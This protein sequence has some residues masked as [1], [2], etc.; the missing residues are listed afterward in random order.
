M[1]IPDPP[2]RPGLWEAWTP[3]QLTAF[4]LIIMGAHLF[5]Q[6]VAYQLTGETFAPVILAAA[7]GVLLPCGVAAW[8][9][10]QSLTTAFD[11][12]GGARQ[13]LIGVVA[14]LLA[15]APAAALAGLSS[16]LRPPT[17]E[18]LAHLAE[19][20]PDDAAGTVL[21]LAAVGVA[22]P[23]AEELVFRG[24]LFR[25]ARDR[26]G[27]TRGMVLT[28][29]FFG[30][31]HFQP[32]SLFGVVGLGAL[33]AVL[34]QWTGSLTAPMVAHGVHNLVSMALLLRWDG[35]TEQP[36]SVVSGPL[37]WLLVSASVALLVLLLA[38]LRRRAASQADG[39]RDD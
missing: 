22:A 12:T 24:L 20:I 35:R 13:M 25:L 30:V 37:Q 9:H 32:W 11:V 27:W 5:W 15:W 3:G 23:V 28:A 10:G 36:D 2:R 33:L 4:A 7:L 26:W 31:M 17:P 21:A 1:P 19:S 39:R 38:A 29:L 34:Y 8:W 18:F 6:L 14:G 16:R